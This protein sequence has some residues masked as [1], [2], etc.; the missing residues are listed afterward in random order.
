MFQSVVGVKVSDGAG[1][2]DRTS[3]GA[4]RG[5]QAAPAVS[6]RGLTLQ[7][8]LAADGNFRGK[9][10]LKDKAFGVLRLVSRMFYAHQD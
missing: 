4:R 7:R 6:S 1:A 9:E 3:P 10:I 5:Q 8:I 2:R